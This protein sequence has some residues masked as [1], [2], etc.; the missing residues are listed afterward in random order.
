MIFHTGADGHPTERRGGAPDREPSTMDTTRKS[1]SY[2]SF[3]SLLDKIYTSITGIVLV[4]F[5]VHHLGLHTYGI[6]V[7]LLTVSGYFGLGNFG[8]PF[9]FEKYIAHF[10]ARRDFVSLRRFIVTAFYASGVLAVLT[11]MVPYFGAPLFFHVLLKNDSLHQHVTVF[12]LLV[13]NLS[14]SL[15]SMIFVAVPRGFQRFDISSIISIAGRTLF[16][17]I[18]IVF[19]LKGFGLYALVIAQFG[20]LVCVTFFSVIVSARYVPRL[21]LLPRFFSWPMCRTLFD[22]GI[23][24]QVSLVS[25]M[26]M[27]SFDKLVI[28]YFLDARTVALYDIGSRLIMFLKDIPSFLYSAVIPRTSELHALDNRDLL[29]KLYVSGTKYLSIVCIGFIPLFFP[30]A[31]NILALWMRT[32]VD[33]L[34]VYVFQVLLVSTM[35]YITTGLGTSIATGMG[36]PGLG[37]LSNTVMVVVN[38]AFS[39]VLY[40]AYGA[41][42]IVWGTAAGMLANTALCFYLLNKWMRIRQAPFW[43]VSFAVP[44]LVN[45]AIVATAFLLKGGLARLCGPRLSEMSF[46]C[47]VVLANG[48]M[49]LSLSALAYKSIRFITLRELAAFMPFANKLFKIKTPS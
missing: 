26:I 15:V 8:I 16:V 36:K 10:M 2:N 19:F 47:I 6:W 13:L 32:R 12:S 29:E 41:Q 46:N 25:L 18:T 31:G 27:Q 42:G 4:P 23:K 37:A 39:I 30:V 7:L 40:F 43:K 17:A 24:M 14:L 33:P 1:I 35:L 48:F 21:N 44:C 9:A 22:F 11:F 5:I 3:F 49:V 28:A 20:F 45:A 34:S 38:V